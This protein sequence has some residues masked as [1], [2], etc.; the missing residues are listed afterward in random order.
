MN[1]KFIKKIV[2]GALAFTM[3]ISS[4]AMA[5]AESIGSAASDPSVGKDEAQGVVTEYQEFTPAYESTITGTDV[6]LTNDTEN[7]VVSVPKKVILSGNYDPIDKKYKG[8][9]TVKVEGDFAGHKLVKVV[10]DNTVDL[11]QQ[12]KK[13]ITANIAQDKTDFNIVDVTNHT[14]TSKGLVSAE[15]LTAGSWNGVFNFNVSIEEVQE[16]KYYSTLAKAVTDANNLT[17]ANADVLEKD[18]STAV[19]GLAIDYPTSTTNIELINDSLNTPQIELT[20]DTNFDMQNHTIKFISNNYMT[21]N[22]NLNLKNGSFSS[23]DS[24]NIIKNVTNDN[25]ILNIDKCNFELNLSENYN[26]NTELIRSISQQNN[27]TN[28]NIKETSKSKNIKNHVMCLFNSPNINSEFN[29]NNTNINFDIANANMAYSI[30]AHQISKSN[31]NNVTADLKCNNVNY[32]QLLHAQHQSHCDIDGLNV[33]T[34]INSQNNKSY[35]DMI[36]PVGSTNISLKNYKCDLSSMN[37]SN[38]LSSAIVVYSKS[39]LTL[40]DNININNN[41]NNGYGI[42]ALDDSNLFITPSLKNSVKIF[43]KRIGL[44]TPS[45]GKAYINGGYYESNNHDAYICG[46][47]EIHDATFV[48]TDGFGFYCGGKHKGNYYN[49]NV[50]NIYNS[51][52]IGAPNSRN[53]SGICTTWNVSDNGNVGPKEIN[54]HDCNVYAGGGRLFYYNININDADSARVNKCTTSFNIYGNTKLFDK[55]KTEITKE[56]LANSIATWRTTVRGQET[57]YYVYLGDEI[58]DARGHISKETGKAVSWNTP[59]ADVHDYRA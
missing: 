6:Y 5:F 50:V 21:Y 3:A 30:V 57:P 44:E 42:V 32:F 41:L 43:G 23:V 24:T 20:Q 22:K 36:V 17:T 19:A 59:E 54:L 25:S 2:T 10:P 12:G 47:A 31:I 52:I 14:N 33:N 38:A 49:N 13:N 15:H 51:T 58:I 27:I 16:Y 18:R 45:K 29:L 35:A 39:T 55:T 9:Y 56:Q 37:N 34:V 4:N 28:S 26:N 1:K 8:E 48:S 11:I 53:G 40:K 7:V 46:S